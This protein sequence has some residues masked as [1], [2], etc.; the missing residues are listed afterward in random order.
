MDLTVLAQQIRYQFPEAVVEE[1]PVALV[2]RKED[3]LAVT[4]WLKN[5]P[6][7]FISL[8]CLTAVDRK[9]T[10]EV[11]Y[12]LYSFEQKFMAALKVV[13]PPVDPA[14]DSVTSLW[15][16]ADWLEREVFDLFGVRFNGHPDLR[17]IMSPDTL[18]GHPLRKDFVGE[19]VI[20]RP[21][22]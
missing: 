5:G 14:V 19:T 9:E 22:T 4:G 6:G 17:R 10:V 16:A 15:K 21:V 7:A 20:R 13:L 1:T 2:L 3:L 11:V 12:L 8:Q 18:V